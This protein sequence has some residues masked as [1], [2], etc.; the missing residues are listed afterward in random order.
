MTKTKSTKRALLMSALALLMCVSMLVGSTFA[1]FTDSVTTA[2][3]TIQSGTLKVDLVDK[4][5]KSL[6][7]EVLEFVDQDENDLWEPGCTYTLEEVYVENKGNLALKYT[8]AINGITGDAKLLEAIEW[9]IKVDGVTTNLEDL[10]GFLLPNTKT[11]A[12]V[13]TGHMK[14]EAGNE[15]QGLTVE[16]I[17]ISVFAT[18]DTVE[19]DSFDEMYDDITL[20]ASADALK[21]A[22][23]EGKNVMLTADVAVD[24][25]ET[26]TV[27]AGAKIFMDLNGKTLSASSDKTSGNVELFVVKGEMT[28]FNGSATIKAA[29]DQNW[30]AMS[31]LFT[32]T[33]GGVLNIK[34]A[35]IDNLG[36]TDMAFGVHLNNW[37]EATLNVDNSTI[38]S[39]YGA[40][41]LFN[42]GYDMNN[43]NVTNSTLIGKMALWVHNYIG[44]LDSTKHSDEAIKNRINVNFMID[45]PV[46]GVAAEDAS[47][48]KAEANNVYVG[49]IMYGFDT[50]RYYYSTNKAVVAATQ[51]AF[52][53]AISGGAET[54]YLASGNYTMPTTSGDVT[55]Y[56]NEDTVITVNKPTANKVTLDGVTVVGSGYTT[57]IQ[58]SNTVVYKDCVLKGTQ[59]LYADKVVIENCVIDLTAT[60]DYIWTYGAKNV[61]FINCTFNTLG[62]AILIYNEGADLV[63]NVSVKGC[64]FNATQTALASGHPAAAIEIDSSLAT[65]GHYTLVTENNTVDSDFAGEWR[66]KKSGT[67]NTTV[68]GTVYNAVTIDGSSVT[69]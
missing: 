43:V 40:I 4:E 65:N 47:N 34:D 1:W 27:P 24:A 14:E 8:I 60:A 55:I 3:N 58:H 41:R 12:I 63:T 23:A 54:I 19:K 59:C 42:A 68:N 69:Y 35:S 31:T 53:K 32:V 26:I 39:T 9:T 7:G 30:N 5:G 52:N 36:G 49:S 18:Q 20:V 67:D 51:D 10:N 6:A 25:D 64:T 56:G 28:V 38:A 29:V 46:E 57:G 15:Y 13:L 48:L 50:H 61:E 16:G 22:I 44:D 45:E 2:G 11:G 33:A 62:K 17:S 66:I 21:A 37:G